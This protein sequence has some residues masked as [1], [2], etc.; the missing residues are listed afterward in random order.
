MQ[1]KVNDSRQ[2][3]KWLFQ[4]GVMALMAKMYFFALDPCGIFVYL[5]VLFYAILIVMRFFR[6]RQK[7]KHFYLLDFCYYINFFTM[8]IA[9]FRPEYDHFFNAV[10]FFAVGVLTWAIPIYRN[11]LIFH[12]IDHMTSLYIH[13][14]PGIIMTVLRWSKGDNCPNY[15]SV[16]LLSSFHFVI[17]LYLTWAVVY[18]LANFVVFYNRIHR[19]KYEILFHFY[20]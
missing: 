13:S 15:G 11:S 20:V 9:V 12:S 14:Q 19:K 7:G 6:F 4:L 18:Y 16:S 5:N 1:R 3:D 10:Y 2:Q 17:P 8:I